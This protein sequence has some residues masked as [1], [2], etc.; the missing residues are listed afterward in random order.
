[1]P[2]TLLDESLWFPPVTDA[3]EDGLLAIG[4]DLS[5]ERLLLAYRNGIFPCLMRMNRLY[6]GVPIRDVFYFLRIVH[7]QKHE[8][9][10]EAECIYSNGEPGF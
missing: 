9:I 6:G 10:T 4:G 8:T 5:T 7:Q 1:M 2:L 3:T